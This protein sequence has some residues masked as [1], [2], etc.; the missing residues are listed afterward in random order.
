MEVFILVQLITREG[1]YEV[2]GHKLQVALKV[3]AHYFELS[4]EAIMK[5]ETSLIVLHLQI[6]S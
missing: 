6:H 2:S 1:I 3:K 4:S 5:L